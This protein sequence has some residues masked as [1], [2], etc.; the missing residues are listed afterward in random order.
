[1]RKLWLLIPCILLLASCSTLS[2]RA[3][4]ELQQGKRLFDAGYYKRSMNYLL[5]LACDG[6][7]EASYAVGYMYYYGYGV[8]QDTDVGAFWIRRSAAKGYVPAMQAANMIAHMQPEVLHA[9][10]RYRTTNSY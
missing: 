9:N 1:M 8:A 10:D 6:N 2:P 4:S 5:P 3:M 7:P